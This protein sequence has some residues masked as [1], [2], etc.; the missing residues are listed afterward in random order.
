MKRTPF[1]LKALEALALG[2]QNNGGF[3]RART[4]AERLWP[5]APAWRRCC[6]VGNGSARG[7]G[8]IRA[9]GSFMAKMRRAGLAEKSYR[10]ELYGYRLS[11]EGRR[12]LEEMRGTEQLGKDG[13]KSP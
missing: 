8:I 12:T 9:G 6:N 7:V 11:G 10:L 2:Q 1:L 3:V 4:F 5:D 13:R